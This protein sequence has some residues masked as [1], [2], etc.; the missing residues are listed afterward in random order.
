MNYAAIGSVFAVLV[1]I[2]GGPLLASAAVGFLY[3]EEVASVFAGIGLLFVLIGGGV[4]LL[5]TRF[6][7]TVRVREG[8]L[9][10]TLTYFVLGLLCT[11][12][13]MV[14]SVNVTQSFT[15]A[16]FESFSGLTTTGATVLTGLEELPRT[17]LFYRASL[18][19]IGGMGIIVL[20]VAIL[21]MLGIGGMQ[22]FR[23]EAPGTITDTSLK[24][25][26]AE[27]AKSLWLLY[28]MLT[29]ACA[30][31]YWVAG[32]SFFD[33]VCHSFTTVA[34]GGF[35]NY[36]ASIGHF[37]EPMIETVAIMFMLLAGLNFSL[38]Y[39]AIIV[40][41]D[42]RE[43]F[44]DPEARTYAIFIVAVTL[45]VMLRLAMA[46]E[47]AGSA[48]RDAL[49]Q[50]VSFAT[51]TGYTTTAVDNW[52]LLCPVLLVLASFVGG[53]VGS[54]AGGI[55][56]YRVL[57]VM[58]Q[59]VREVRRLILPDGVFTVKLGSEVVADRVIEAVWGFVTMYGLL[60][61]FLLT[62][63]L[64]VSDL[65]IK[66]AFSAVAACLNNL[67]PGLGEVANHY[68]SLNAPTKW[69]LIL[70]MVLGRLEIFTLLVLLAPR[71]WYR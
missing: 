61:L 33:A 37:D 1:M 27:A 13:F 62:C 70:A 64:M 36:D 45:L 60:F 3:G 41:T 11:L 20:A 30:L 46:E 12:P 26:I 55:K 22:L 29:L 57:V 7:R 17:F 58:Q 10:T 19:W 14:S 47:M 32:M 28:L 21:P 53:C 50:A 38:H 39:R 59:G 23:A 35:S 16:A 43:Y 31:A 42:I 5:L 40:K 24:P 4:H 67:G 15:D 52:P 51:T 34:I 68:A 66:S 56:I 2:I 65:D 9:I 44:R 71:Y 8:F 25:R 6:D 69:L 54:T 48:F 63:V 18:Q 49:F